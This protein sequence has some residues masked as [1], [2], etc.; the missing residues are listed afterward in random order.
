[1]HLWT[2]VSRSM[3]RQGAQLT[4]RHSP[5]YEEYSDEEE[6][7]DCDCDCHYVECDHEPG[8]CDCEEIIDDEHDHHGHGHGHGHHHHDHDHDHDHGQG[9]EYE[10][11]Y[12]D[13]A[14]LDGHTCE[15]V[16]IPN[17]YLQKDPTEMTYQQALEA[18]R[19]NRDNAAR[20]LDEIGGMFKAAGWQPEQRSQ[21]PLSEDPERLVRAPS[22]RLTITDP[23]TKRC[24]SCS[25][26]SRLSYGRLSKP[27]SSL[28][29]G[30]HDASPY[31][32][33]RS[34]VDISRA[35]S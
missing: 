19:E 28:A 24:G 1:V 31:C 29:G 21:R 25:T 16:T 35:W 30:G 2:A 13:E 5:V 4:G 22:A 9:D 6:C 23:R 32:I 11:V 10:Y 3:A 7:G 14:D 26:G 33:S 20:G 27:Q 15:P 34:A 12:E 17:P 8:T 18:Y